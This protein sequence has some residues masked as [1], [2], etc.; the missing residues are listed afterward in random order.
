SH[1]VLVVDRRHR[2]RSRR[3][4]RTTR[5][6]GHDP[7]RRGHGRSDHRTAGRSD[8]RPAHRPR[9]LSPVVVAGRRWSVPVGV[10][11]HTQCS[12]SAT[13]TAL[14]TTNPRLGPA[15][16]GAACAWSTS[17]AYAGSL[18][19]AIC[20]VAT[21]LLTRDTLVVSGLLSARWMLQPGRPN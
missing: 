16:I 12:P 18:G 9:T 8:R 13:H 20:A 10:R 3:W 17:P 21:P 7:H 19:R 1:D 15:V 2:Q 5:R 11:Q 4:V 14:L 6:P